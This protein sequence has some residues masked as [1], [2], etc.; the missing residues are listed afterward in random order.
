MRGRSPKNGDT[1]NLKSISP[2]ANPGTPIVPGRVENSPQSD[3]CFT[4][5]TRVTMADGTTRPIEE[6]TVGDL[7]IGAGGAVNRVE[8]IET[9]QLGGRLLYALNDGYAFVTAEHPFMTDEGW[10]AVDP[11]ATSRENP[12]LIVGKLQVGDRLHALCG[13]LAAVGAGVGSGSS[14][15]EIDV[16]QI[17]LHGID[18]QTADANMVVYNLR[19]DGNH[20]YF[21]NDLLVHNK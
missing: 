16:A 18:Q 11:A 5:D 13:V 4:A 15:V 2:V 1:F 9:P 19:L 12:A 20:T 6:V 3:S 17:E 8:S 14:S 10:K 21:A 7:V